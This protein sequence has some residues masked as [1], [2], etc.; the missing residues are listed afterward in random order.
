ML[1]QLTS[2]FT[3]RCA[4]NYVMITT[5]HVEGESPAALSV[6]KLCAF[7]V[8]SVVCNRWQQL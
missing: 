3:A 2:V 7:R 4:A 8:M 5:L 6:L 1:T